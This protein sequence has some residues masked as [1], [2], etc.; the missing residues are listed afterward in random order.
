MMGIFFPGLKNISAM[1]PGII[2]RY[3][4]F[5]S[6]LSAGY[7]SAP[8]LYVNIKTKHYYNEKDYLN[9]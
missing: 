6:L 1:N 7:A 2:K 9:I 3:T 5:F 8:S 4:S